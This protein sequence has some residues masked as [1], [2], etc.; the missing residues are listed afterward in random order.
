MSKCQDAPLK[1]AA[2][3]LVDAAMGVWQVGNAF[4]VGAPLTTALIRGRKSASLT[5]SSMQDAWSGM[6]PARSMAHLIFP[7][8]CSLTT[9]R[10]GFR[11]KS[12][13]A[14]ARKGVLLPKN[15]GV[16]SVR[17]V[18]NRKR[19]ISARL[20]QALS[21]HRGRFYPIVHIVR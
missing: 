4:G 7:P 14:S 17:D 8:W 9:C 13:K 19:R 3:E 15:P 6:N 16:V 2:E 21:S 10:M 20:R 12:A 11:A 5:W 1:S 18:Q